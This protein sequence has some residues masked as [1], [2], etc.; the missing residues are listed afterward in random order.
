M[1]VAVRSVACNW[2]E[3]GGWIAVLMLVVGEWLLHGTQSNP[4]AYHQHLDSHS[5]NSVTGRSALPRTPFSRHYS[6]ILIKNVPRES[7]AKDF[8]T[9]SRRLDSRTNRFDGAYAKQ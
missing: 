8:T 6:A 4:F 5:R 9:T 3:L 2:V 7:D 1:K